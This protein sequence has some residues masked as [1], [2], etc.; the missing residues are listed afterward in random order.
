[1]G[2]A[3][4]LVLIAGGVGLQP[5]GNPPLPESPPAAGGRGPARPTYLSPDEQR[6]V[7]VVFS[8]ERAMKPKDRAAMKTARFHVF[9]LKKKVIDAMQCRR[10]RGKGLT[11]GAARVSDDVA[12]EVAT[13]CSGCGG[14]RITIGGPVHE[15][16][17]AFGRELYRFEYRYP[18]AAPLQTGLERWLIENVTTVE[19]LRRLNWDALERLRSG[20]SRPGDMYVMAV[21]CFARRN[22]KGTPVLQAELRPDNTAESDLNLMLLMDGQ[23]DRFP[24]TARLLV[25]AIDEGDVYYRNIFGDALTARALTAID[26]SELRA[27]LLPWDFDYGR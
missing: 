5:R 14:T 22:I 27:E 12:E 3:L 13:A 18:F 17:A 21:Q 20:R 23:D 1:M 4:G 26:V 11:R 6:S 10:C 19:A 2:I 15:A 7:G 8:D 25:L 9:R 24:A 16:L